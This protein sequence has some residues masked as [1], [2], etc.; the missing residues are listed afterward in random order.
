MG[1]LTSR[2]NSFFSSELGWGQVK[3]DDLL[4][5]IIH[6]INK[7]GKV[8]MA[9]IFLRVDHI[10]TVFRAPQTGREASMASSTSPLAGQRRVNARPTPANGYNR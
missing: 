2:R 5:P 9:N 8:S 6:K 4:L 1:P 3:V 10:L 7:R